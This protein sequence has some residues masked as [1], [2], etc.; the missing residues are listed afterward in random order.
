MGG[1]ASVYVSYRK[2]HNTTNHPDAYL[3]ASV[4]D[5]LVIHTSNVAQPFDP[6]VSR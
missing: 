6:A 2:R 4:A 1:E 5:Q 3:P